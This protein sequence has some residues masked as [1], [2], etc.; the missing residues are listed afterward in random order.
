M[1]L[2]RDGPQRAAAVE[3]LAA[4][5]LADGEIVTLLTPAER[6]WSDKLRFE[7][8]FTRR[9]Q[10]SRVSQELSR[11]PSPARDIDLE[12]TAY[13]V[14]LPGTADAAERFPARVDLGQNALGLG[15][16]FALAV[17]FGG[18][19]DP[20]AWA[21]WTGSAAEMPLPWPARGAA[22]VVVRAGSGPQRPLPA[23]VRLLLDGELL[24]E[25]AAVPGEMTE[26][27]FPVPSGRHAPGPHRRLRIESSTW[28]PREQGL[29]GYPDGLGL[30]VDWIEIRPFTVAGE[31]GE[32]RR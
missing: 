23:R 29:R 21:R 17:Q 26:L 18:G 4:R 6:P 8:L 25:N 12:Y 31:A 14:G 28:N 15:P 10:T 3:T 16:G 2:D 24:G 1:I 11:H 27:I 19:R 32:T 20:R 7:P 9:L 30:L 5:R 13:R 22:V